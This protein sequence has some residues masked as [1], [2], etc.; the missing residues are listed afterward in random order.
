[1]RDD[2][3]LEKR[4]PHV[5]LVEVAAVEEDGVGVVGLDVSHCRDEASNAAVTLIRIYMYKKSESV[6]I[7][8]GARESRK[9]WNKFSSD[10]FSIPVPK[11]ADI[12]L[13]CHL[14]A[15]LH[16]SFTHQI[17]YGIIIFILP[18][19]LALKKL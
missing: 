17:Y 10:L 9:R 19:P 8:K 13:H 7:E 1:V 3:P 2:T 12:W 5:A 11:M 16:F 4:V 15:R 18:L 14:S 6:E